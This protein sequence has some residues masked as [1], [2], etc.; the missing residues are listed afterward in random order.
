MP[1]SKLLFNSYFTGK[2]YCLYGTVP[3]VID[4]YGIPGSRLY[5]TV[6]AEVVY[7]YHSLVRQRLRHRVRTCAYYSKKPRLQ[8]V[9]NRIYYAVYISNSLVYS[10]CLLSV[11]SLARIGVC[12]DCAIEN[13]FGATYMHTHFK[14]CIAQ[15]TRIHMNNKAP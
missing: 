9:P 4:C 11:L 12:P 7:I 1:C 5:G 14:T 3:R 15:K 8:P 6:L 10:P 13:S 2:R